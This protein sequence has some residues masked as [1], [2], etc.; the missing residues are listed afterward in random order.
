MNYQRNL[1]Y[2]NVKKNHFIVMKEMKTEIKTKLK[3]KS[4]YKQ[5][6]QT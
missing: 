3:K 4:N 1:R 6:K 5:L 2:S